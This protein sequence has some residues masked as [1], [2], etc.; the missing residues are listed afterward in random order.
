MSAEF[1]LGTLS[2]AEREILPPKGEA[3]MVERLLGVAL[4]RARRTRGM[5]MRIERGT[6]RYSEVNYDRHKAL[7]QAAKHARRLIRLKHEIAEDLQEQLQAEGIL[8]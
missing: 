2:L 1:D 5:L 8:V 6:P 7:E 4:E 3:D